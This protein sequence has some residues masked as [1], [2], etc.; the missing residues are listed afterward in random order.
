[1]I[2]CF[3]VDQFTGGDHN[4]LLTALGMTTLHFVG[5]ELLL[6]FGISIGALRNET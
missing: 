1:M 6:L 5:A 4:R 2:R 3:G